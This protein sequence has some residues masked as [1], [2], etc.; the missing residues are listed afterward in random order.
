[1]RHLRL[2]AARADSPARQS[3]SPVGRGPRGGRLLPLAMLRERHPDLYARHLAKY[4]GREHRLRERVIPL[5][6]AWADV[7]FFSPLDSALLFDAAR[8]AGRRVYD[9]PVRTLDASRLDPARC[10]VRLMRVTPG[11][12]TADPG[13]EDDYL[14]LTTA[15]LRAVSEVTDRALRRLRALGPDEPLPLWGDVAHVLHRGP[16]PFDL[17]RER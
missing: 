17:F 12:R 7:F 9:G 4:T 13:T 1:M 8:G 5:D 16:V 15:T 3:S 11:A 2:A 10:C 14:P 6:C